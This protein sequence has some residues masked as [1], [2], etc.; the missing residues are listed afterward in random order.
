M[1]PEAS[2]DS[3]TAVSAVAL[4][5]VSL[6]A[7]V[8]VTTA[9]QPSAAP[10]DIQY[11]YNGTVVHGVQ[12]SYCW[13]VLLRSSCTDTAAPHELVSDLTPNRIPHNA[14]IRFMAADY[15]PLERYVAELQHPNGTVAYRG[16]ATDGVRMA[17]DRGQYTL[18]VTGH[19]EK[20]EVS[21]VFP[22]R[23]V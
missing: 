4:L 9:I 11:T 21:Y 5:V 3:D 20:G 13:T 1:I 8:F 23:I 22:V 10:P 7:T 16:T 17:V 15:Q 14:S 12:G 19:W 2:L 18:V 6:I